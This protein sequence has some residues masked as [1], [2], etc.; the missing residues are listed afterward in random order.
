VLLQFSQWGYLERERSAA[1]LNEVDFFSNL[2]ITDGMTWKDKTRVLV[3][4]LSKLPQSPM[5]LKHY[6]SP[7]VYV[8]EIFMSAASIVIGKVHKTEHLNIIQRGR[9]E[10]FDESGIF[11]L[12][13]PITFTSKA[14]VQKVLYIQEDTV[15]STV[16]VTEET[17]LEKLECE[18]IE[19]DHLLEYAA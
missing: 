4:E 9:V 1:V 18:L 3:Q 7:G 10:I 17:D 5:P 2:P 14:G 13:G 12:Q 6:F 8:R 19:P 16:H 15:W 11:T